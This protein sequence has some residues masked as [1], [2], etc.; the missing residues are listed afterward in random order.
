MR[1]RFA[2]PL[3]AAL[4]S[5]FGPALAEPSRPIPAKTHEPDPLPVPKGAMT[6]RLVDAPKLCPGCDVIVASGDIEYTSAQ[7]FIAFFDWNKTGG[8]KTVFIV[9]SSGG[10]VEAGW[11]IGRKLRS[12][13]ASV[14][15]GRVEERVDGSIELKSGICVSMCNS[16]LISGTERRIVPGT[17]FGIHQFS[18]WNATFANLDNHV[19][20]R[21]VRE[22]LVF[23]G[24][25]LAFAREMGSD[26]RLVEAQFGIVSEKV[27][28]IDHDT[29]ASWKVTNAPAASLPRILRDAGAASGP[30][31]ALGSPALARPVAAVVPALKPTLGFAPVAMPARSL[32]PVS[33]KGDRQWG[34][35][36]AN[37]EWRESAVESQA[38]SA[39]IIFACSVQGRGAIQINLRG[40]PEARQKQIAQ[41]IVAGGMSFAGRPVDT[42]QTSMGFGPSF[43]VKFNLMPDQASAFMTLRGQIAFMPGDA[44]QAGDPGLMVNFQTSGFEIMVQKA[45]QSCRDEAT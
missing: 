22:Q 37:G 16:L 3:V 42:T 2:L 17:A 5:G 41:L 33:A 39:K 30:I 8:K 4:A 24:K 10:S 45:R 1:L 11:Q 25:W 21:D 32:A 7:D 19:T 28:F 40:I 18:T 13:S 36:E 15:A 44:K 12:L 35:L 38:D 43:W 9:D 14:I 6:F 23:A 27:D 34:P 29:L 26:S 20:V 31:Q